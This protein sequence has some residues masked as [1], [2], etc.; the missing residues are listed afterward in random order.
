MEEIISAISTASGTGGVAII[1]ASGENVLGLAEKMFKPLSKKVKVKDFEPY[2]MYVGE[3]DGG[4][5]TD[6][7]MMVYFKAPK[8]YTGEDMIEFHCHGGVVIT[9]GILKRTYE[10]GAI[11]ATR[12][13]FTKR[14]FVNGKLSLDSAEGLINMINSE[15]TA[16]LKVGSKRLDLCFGKCRCG[17]RLSRRRLRERC[18]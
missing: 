7:G 8:S 16:S 17:Y 4:D 11:P 18:S 6:F 14:A 3:I 15:S 13:E 2:K 5:F 10:L 9:Q 12:G 1:R